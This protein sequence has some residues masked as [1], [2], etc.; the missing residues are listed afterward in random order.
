MWACNINLI[1]FI[2]KIKKYLKDINL[3]IQGSRVGIGNID[4]LFLTVH[5]QRLNKGTRKRPRA[6]NKDTAAYQ[7]ARGFVNVTMQHR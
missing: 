3:N 2:I 6:K 5:Q 4:T 7:N 1:K